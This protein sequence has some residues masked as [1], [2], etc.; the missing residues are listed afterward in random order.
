M[1]EILLT[2]ATVVSTIVSI[3][4]L[5]KTRQF[6]REVKRAALSSLT[7]SKTAATHA[8]AGRKYVSD[9]ATLVAAA[10]LYSDRAKDHTNILRDLAA[11]NMARVLTAPPPPVPTKEPEDATVAGVYRAQSKY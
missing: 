10:K 3:Y 1:I 6:T 2:V 4:T 7:N 9:A 5:V 11:S 8:S